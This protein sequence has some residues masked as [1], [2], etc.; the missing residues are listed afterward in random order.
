MRTALAISTRTHK[1]LLLLYPRELRERFEEEMTEV[2]ERQLQDSWDESGLAGFAR[3]WAYA[4]SDL[5]LVALPMQLGQP[6]IVA[7]M[8]SLIWNSL[9]FLMLF[10]EMAPLAALLRVTGN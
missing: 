6:I 1:A 10:R 9:M 5:A 4:L 2:F 8:I 7:P 3:T